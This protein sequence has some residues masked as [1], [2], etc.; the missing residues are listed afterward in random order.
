[1]RVSRRRARVRSDRLRLA[2]TRIVASDD[3]IISARNATVGSV[4]QNGQEL[5]RLIRQGRLEWRAE[6][7][8]AELPAI[9]PGM[10]ARIASAGAEPFSGRVRAVAPTVDPQTRNAIVYVDLAE[11]SDARA[12][13]F[14]RGEFELGRSP[15]MALPQSAVLPRDGFSYVFRIGPGDRVSRVKVGTGRRNGDRVEIVGG[16]EP[17]ARVVATGGGFLNDGDLV[18]VVGPAAAAAGAGR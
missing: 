17:G 13:M 5:F 9:K 4:V 11:G 3:G 16:L 6:V 10:A 1:V 12:G 14:A 8:A 15:G 2:Q 7:G 18:R